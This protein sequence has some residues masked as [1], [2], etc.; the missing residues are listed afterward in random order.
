[1]DRF[2]LKT[3]IVFGGGAVS[4]LETLKNER[5]M[6]IA[7]PFIVTSGMIKL[8]TDHLNKCEVHVFSD[9]VPDP[10]M[11]KIAAGIVAMNGFQPT[12]LIACG[13]GSAIDSAKG[14]YFYGGGHSENG[15]TCEQ[16]RIKRFIAI[17]TTSG[18]GSEVTKFA[19]ITDGATG[20]KYPL[21]NDALIPD[22]AVLDVDFVKS[23]PGKVAADT[24]LDVLTHAIEAYVSKDANILTDALAE[25]AVKIV[26]EYLERS[27]RSGEDLEAREKMHEASLLAGIAFNGASL[28]LNHAIAHNL[29]GRLHIP[30][31]RINAILLCPVIW[32]NADITGFSQ[33]K[34][35]EAALKYAKLAQVCGVSASTVRGQVR[36]LMEKIHRFMKALDMPL[37]L[38][39]AGIAENDVKKIENDAAKGAVLDACMQTNPRTADEKQIIEIIHRL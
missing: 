8:V 2:S 17:P 31:G 9:V 5:I 14:I 39:E 37:N 18:T 12:V 30:H 19:V 13:G 38:K 36:G 6:V 11:E 7:D 20:Q 34:C 3:E 28:G 22:M 4:V 23:V 35:S 24:G 21:V 10:P 27:Y 32:F 26:F 33:M 16:Q 15:G 25:K 1:M 29:G